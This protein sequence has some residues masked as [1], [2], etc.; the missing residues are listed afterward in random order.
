MPR[1]NRR[2]VS[3]LFI[4]LVACLGACLGL[5]VSPAMA[6]HPDM[7]LGP[8]EA[9]V[10]GI[11]DE[12]LIRWS[13]FGFVY[14]A[15]QQHSHLT[16]TF[17]K[18]ANTLLYRDTGT[19]RLISKPK[20]CTRKKADKGIAVECKIPKAFDH[21]K[22]FVQVWPRLGNDFVDGRTLPHKF[23]LWVLADAGNDTIWGGAGND[24]TNGAFDSDHVYGGPGNDLLRTGPGNDFVWG[25][26]GKDRLSCAENYD[27]A[28]KDKR[29]SM[30]QCERVIHVK[31]SGGRRAV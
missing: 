16:V 29:D 8:G 22:M 25:G 11:K 23:R 20:N 4:T 21:K 9:H 10:N 14:I 5:G 18:D 2:P 26:Q 3:R 13:R 31:T 24:F 12:A 27:V 7:M 6:D 1:T 17:D 30:Y 15:G 28:H 19:K